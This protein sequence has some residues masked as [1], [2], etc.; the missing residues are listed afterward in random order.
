MEPLTVHPSDPLSACASR[1]VVTV[2]HGATLTQIASVMRREDVS[3]V[4]VGD[5]GDLASSGT[6]RDLVEALAGRQGPDDAIEA[7]GAHEPVAIDEG[8]TV[9]DAAA[10]MLRLGVRHLVVTSGQQ[11]IGIVSMRDALRAF[12]TTPSTDALLVALRESLTSSTEYWL[13]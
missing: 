13:G 8:A 1:P 12:S 6:E 7:V 9:V 4:L 5:P 2:P 11:A 10:V 3:S